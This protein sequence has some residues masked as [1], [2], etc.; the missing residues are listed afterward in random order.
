MVLPAAPA[1]AVS[2]PL[3]VEAVKKPAN[4]TLVLPEGPRPTVIISPQSSAGPSAQSSGSRESPSAGTSMSMDARDSKLEEEMRKVKAAQA[5]AKT[6]A[7]PLVAEPANAKRGDVSDP[8]EI[9]S[10]T[11]QEYKSTIP[12]P[13][14]SP[15]MGLSKAFGSSKQPSQPASD[16]VVSSVPAPPQSP[17]PSSSSAANTVS[18]AS[19]PKRATFPSSPNKVVSPGTAVITPPSASA[20]ALT[21]TE[22]SGIVGMAAN[23]LVS[24]AKG[25]LGAIWSLGGEGVKQ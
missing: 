20:P 2:A 25:M 3:P 12:T 13:S 5:A 14:N 15:I 17:P 10:G 16:S 7:G 6:A 19:T 4:S 24:S 11:F 1:A 9:E 22:E 8:E 23:S 21:P 18:P